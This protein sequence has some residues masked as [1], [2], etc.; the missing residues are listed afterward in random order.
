MLT[1]FRA[2]NDLIEPMGPLHPALP[3][4]AISS[5][6]FTRLFLYYPLTSSRLL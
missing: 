4:S 6:T 3:Q 2:I 1:D 5:N